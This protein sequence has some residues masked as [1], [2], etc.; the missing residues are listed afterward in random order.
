MSSADYNDADHLVFERYGRDDE[1]VWLDGPQAIVRLTVRGWPSAVAR[2]VANHARVIVSPRDGSAESLRP[3]Q[4]FIK[5][6]QESPQGRYDYDEPMAPCLHFGS[7]IPAPKTFYPIND[8][9]GVLRATLRGEPPVTLQRNILTRTGVDIG[10]PTLSWRQRYEACAFTWPAWREDLAKTLRVLDNQ[11]LFGHDT[12]EA[13]AQK[14]WGGSTAISPTEAGWVGNDPVSHSVAQTAEYREITFVFLIFN[15]TNNDMP[16]PEPLFE[17]LVTRYPTL[18]WM[19]ECRA[20]DP[21]H[22]ERT[23][24]HAVGAQGQV[25]WGASRTLG[26]WGPNGEQV[27]DDTLEVDEDD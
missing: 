27:A 24:S 9:H 17:A 22:D 20:F 23:F 8:P 10:D 14:H 19:L 1:F 13:W 3:W 7:I 26:P 25:T 18:S 15:E 4:P 5:G 11:K 2:F 16:C 12:I 6:A 21:R